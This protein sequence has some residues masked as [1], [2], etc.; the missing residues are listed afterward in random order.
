MKPDTAVKTKV[1]KS[2]APAE[3]FAGNF[4]M[5]KVEIPAAFRDWAE[6]G[7]A[8]AKSAYEKIRATAEETT[9]LL[10]DAY[11]TTAKGTADY[12]LKMIEA[13][14]AN[15]NAVFDLAR[16]LISAKSASEVIEVS[17]G[18]ARKQFDVMSAQGRELAELA[19]KVTMDAAS[20]VRNG[21]TKALAKAS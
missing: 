16:D 14:Q 18:H 6:K 19:Q 13:A 4:E 7:L 8:Q 21:I 3:P 11:T 1:S 5:P 12:S 10:E 15:T 2:A 9:S 20:P 17:T